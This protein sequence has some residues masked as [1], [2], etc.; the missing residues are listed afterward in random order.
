MAE[1]EEKTDTGEYLTPQKI[2][3]KL[4]VSPS[5]VRRW[6]ERRILP[7]FKIDKV[8]RIPCKAFKDF[9]REHMTDAHQ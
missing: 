5:T 8:Y 9:V 2:S 3:K 7:A 6:V 4:D 1:E